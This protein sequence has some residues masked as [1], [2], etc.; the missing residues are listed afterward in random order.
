MAA[1]KDIGGASEGR[2]AAGREQSNA[3]RVLG[4]RGRVLKKKQLTRLRPDLGM[5][6]SGVRHGDD[7]ST[8]QT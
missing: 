3:P 6:T 4:K 5:T 2:G 1:N 7:T 8:A